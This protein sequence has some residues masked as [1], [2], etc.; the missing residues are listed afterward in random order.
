MLQVISKSGEL[1]EAHRNI[2]EAFKKFGAETLSRNVG[3]HGGNMDVKIQWAEELRIWHAGRI[4][5][6]GRLWNGFGTMSPK[7]GKGSL[8][9]VCEI[10]FPRVGIDRRIGGAVLSDGE[11]RRILGHRGKIGGGKK[12]VCKQTFWNRFEGKRLVVQD[13]DRESEIA[14]V[15][16]FHS[17]RFL[18]QLQWFVFE[19]ERIRTV[20]T[21]ETSD[22]GTARTKAHGGGSAEKKSSVSW[23]DEFAGTKHYLVKQRISAECDHGLIVN[24]LRQKLEALNHSV[25]NDAYRDLYVHRNGRMTALFE[26]KPSPDLQSL[27]TAIGQLIVHSTGLKRRPTLCLVAPKGLPLQIR[28]A[29]SAVKIHLLEFEWHKGAPRFERLAEWL[30]GIR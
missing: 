20:E 24:A 15:A 19:V 8:S 12:G 27:Y 5:P 4:L 28:N 30:A 11:G 2:R 13:G 14:V 16:D 25:G 6:G 18:K 26:V 17:P 7:S 29:L 1:L 23:H 9:L 3:F 22:R 10:N 21:R